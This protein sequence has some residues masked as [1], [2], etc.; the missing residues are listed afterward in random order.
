MATLLHPSKNNIDICKAH[1]EQSGL[2]AVPTETVYGLAGNALDINALKL[3]FKTK[4][5]PLIDPLIIHFHSLTQIENYA[6]LN[7]LAKTLMIQFC[8]GPLTLILKKKTLVPDLVTANLSSVAVRCP[9][10]PVFRNLLKALSFPL[11]APSANPFGYISPTSAMH[12]QDSLGKRISYILDGGSCDFGVEST[13]IDVQDENKPTILRP[14]PITKEMLEK[15][16]NQEFYTHSKNKPTTE[17]L[18]PGMLENHYS[19][20]KKLT[21]IQKK[22]VPNLLQQNNDATTKKSAI[23]LN[24]RPKI[25][26]KKNIYWL[27]ENGDFEEISK[28]LYKLLRSLDHSKHYDE[29]LIEAIERK[30]LGIALMDRIQKAAFKGNG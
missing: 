21:I 24:K 2:I 23:V 30:E 13:I 27:S 4:D 15:S 29:I 7:P 16:F 8:P 6:H 25:L 1:L 5:R 19:P 12:V 9:A 28:N 17:M 26:D 18:A 14:G 11:A 20:K 3:I 10:H 22:E